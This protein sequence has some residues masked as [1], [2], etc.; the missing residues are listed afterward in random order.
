MRYESKRDLPETLRD[1]L[2]EEAQDIYLEAYKKAWED[3]REEQ[4]GDLSRGSV[5][6]QQG[7]AAVK[8]EFVQSE[9]TGEWHRKGEEPDKEDKSLL[10][11]VR[12]LF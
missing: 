8:R 10:D 4:A 1:V 3:Y 2:P 6:H 7:W 12:D 5:A 9:K 11:E